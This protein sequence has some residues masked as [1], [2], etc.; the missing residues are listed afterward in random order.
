MDLGC[1]SFPPQKAGEGVHSN[2]CR[3]AFHLGLLALHQFFLHSGHCCEDAA[4]ED[5]EEEDLLHHRLEEGNDDVGILKVLR[6]EGHVVVVPGARTVKSSVDA[7]AILA[8]LDVGAAAV[9]DDDEVVAVLLT[10]SSSMLIMRCC[11]WRWIL[12]C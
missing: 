12:S 5:D 10:V 9:G 6:L 8:E 1:S 2:F 4:E 7:A 3:G 11:C